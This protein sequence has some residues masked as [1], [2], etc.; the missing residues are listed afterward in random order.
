MAKEAWD[1]TKNLTPILFARATA[2]GDGKVTYTDKDGKEQSIPADSVV[3]A[4]G[5]QPK[6]KLAMKFADAAD[7]FFAIGDCEKV[8]SIQT[9]MRSAYS[10]A[11]MI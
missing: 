8:G 4:V 6:N 10:S 5:Y 11:C 7:R 1:N 9:V 2:I 3:I